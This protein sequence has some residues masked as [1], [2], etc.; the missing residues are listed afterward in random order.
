MYCLLHYIYT[1]MLRIIFEA[2][3]F[4]VLFVSKSSS[5]CS[6]ISLFRLNVECLESR[7]F[8]IRRI[9]NNPNK[10]AHITDFR[11]H[12]S[13]SNQVATNLPSSFISQA[14]LACGV[15]GLVV[16][17]INKFLNIDSPLSDVQSRAGKFVEDP[18]RLVSF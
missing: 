11:R 18:D 4:V 2:L 6:K 12:S 9:I 1:T 3:L 7:H 13:N 8:Q 16:I 14:S 5:F 15:L 17:L 10:N